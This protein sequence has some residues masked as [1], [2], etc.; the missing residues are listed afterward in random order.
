MNEIIQFKKQR[1]LGEILT[2][3][4]KFIRI[5]WKPLFG[6]ILKNT[7]PALLIVLLAFIYYTQ[8]TIMSI[9]DLSS[10]YGPAEMFTGGVIISL[11]VL[12][13]A[14]ISFYSLLY[15]TILYYIKSHVKNEGIVDKEEVNNGVKNSFWN[16]IGLSFLVALI[17]GAGLIFCVIP[18]LYLGTVL[19]TTFAIHVMEKRDITDAISY[20]FE[21]IKGEWWMTFATL[22]VVF[23][24]YYILMF[25][26]QLP[27]YI[28]FFIK[29]F[30][31]LQEISADPTSMFDWT[32]I[33]LNVI[34]MIAQYL[35]YTFIVIATVFIYYNLNEK[36]NFTGTMEA[37]E[38]IGKED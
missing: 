21:L 17:T 3:T 27:Q 1:D 14:A 5:N 35:T 37:I 36:K 16:L 25:V 2:D 18:G 23:I 26:F 19:A 6:L 38:T 22:F 33:A 11:L 30:T 20:S 31:M 12:L 13:F 4:F 32:Y 8:S 28:Y 7:G 9:G 15:G 10:I 29:S 24:L 34:A